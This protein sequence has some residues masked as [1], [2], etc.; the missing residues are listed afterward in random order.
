MDKNLIDMNSD[1]IRTVSEYLEKLNKNYKNRTTIFRGINN[2]FKILPTIVR[3][4][5]KNQVIIES[6]EGFDKT[7]Y[8]KKCQSWLEGGVSLN[9]DKDSK[10]KFYKYE[11]DLF[12]SF[13]RQARMH[14]GNIPRNDWEW[15]A[16]AQ[17]H[18][19]PTRLL[20][21]TKNPLAG[22][23]FAVAGNDSQEDTMEEVSVYVIRIWEFDEHKGHDRFG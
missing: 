23:F 14:V 4:F 18:G 22:L 17:H 2:R 12:K 9:E 19:L 8:K 1:Y 15:L 3:S 10:K 7:Q 16:L 5:C 13:K 6:R 20:D 21:W 11:M